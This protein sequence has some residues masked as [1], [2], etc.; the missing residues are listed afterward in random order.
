MMPPLIIVGIPSTR[1]FKRS[2]ADA[3]D[4]AAPACAYQVGAGDRCSM[5]CEKQLTTTPL[6]V[7]DINDATFRALD[8]SKD[9]PPTTGH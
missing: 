3:T 4:R 2:A 6:Y 7:R 5:I 8:G 9:A 1:R